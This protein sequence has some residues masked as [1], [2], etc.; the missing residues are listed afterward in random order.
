[1]QMTGQ[2]KWIMDGQLNERAQQ[3]ALTHD[4]R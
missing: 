1:M 3:D 4:K 2:C